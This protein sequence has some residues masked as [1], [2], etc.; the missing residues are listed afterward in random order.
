VPDP[1]DLEGVLRRG[2]NPLRGQQ[3][4]ARAATPL[5]ILFLVSAHN[6]LSQRALVA[7]TELGHQVDVAIV[8]SPEAMEAAVA[9]HEPELIVCPMLKK[10]IPESVWSRHRCLVVHPGP[11]GDRG[12]SALD[13]AIDLEMAELPRARPMSSPGAPTRTSC[14]ATR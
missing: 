12:P 13:W 9:Q 11:V 6:S 3:A 7:L 2:P 8:D 4:V 10:I 5:R 14:C 1:P